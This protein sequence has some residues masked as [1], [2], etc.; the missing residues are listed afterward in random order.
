MND[1]AGQCEHELRAIGEVVT[2]PAV[3]LTIPA[4]TGTLV[5]PMAVLTDP[6]DGQWKYITHVGGFPGQRRRIIFRSTEAG[7]YLIWCRVL[8]PDTGNDSFFVKM[9]TG[10]EEI[11]STAQGTWTNVWQ[12]TRVNGGTWMSGFRRLI[13]FRRAATRWPCVGRESYTGLL[14]SDNYQRSQLRSV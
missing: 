3:T 8:S 11:Y 7:D 13:R 5:A 4:E 1:G 12:W 10:T 6:L 14:P 9:D 2:S